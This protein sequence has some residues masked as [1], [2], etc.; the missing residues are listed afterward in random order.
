[1]KLK[2]ILVL[3][4]VF[5]ASCS[6]DSQN[7]IQKLPSG[8]EIKIL[9]IGKIFLKK[10]K[11]VL[12]LK[13]QTDVDIKNVDLLRKEVEEIWPMFRINVEKSKY[14]NAIIAATSQPVKKFLI[15]STNNSYNFVASKKENGIWD[16]NSWKRDYNEEA[17]KIAERH[18]EALKNG[19]I[20]SG[21]KSSPM[22]T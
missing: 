5:I 14:S 6:S 9:S 11:P 4:T 2:F 3:A 18:L 1:M 10:D 8:K 17:K 22:A 20:I 12:M 13:Y 21:V 16:L 15:F 7:T 19:D